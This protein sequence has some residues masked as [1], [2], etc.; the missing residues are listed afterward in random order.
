M[1]AIENNRPRLSELI[2]VTLRD[3]IESG[4]LPA[5]LILEAAPLARFFDLSRTP[6]K[7]ALHGLL[8][9]GLV[10]PTQG[11]GVAVGPTGTPFRQDLAA[12]GLRLPART[13]RSFTQRHWRTRFYPQT[14][15]EI[16]ACL[17]F[18]RFA[19]NV[20]QFAAHKGVS[21]TLANETLV[22]LERLGLIRQQGTRWYA[23]PLTETDIDEHYEMRWLLEPCAL[24]QS[25]A[26]LPAAVLDAA[27]DRAIAAL[28]DP[29][30][31]T[32]AMLDRSETDIHRT[33]VL[34]AP[35]RQMAEAIRRS[36]LPLMATNF[37]LKHTK[38]HGVMHQTLKE[39]FAVLEHLS[40]GDAEGAA[41]ALEAHLK[42]ARQV[43]QTTLRVPNLNFEPPAYM[44]RES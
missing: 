20:S 37:S 11:R 40:H 27:L 5:G 1:T 29:E 34:H 31:I 36:Q 38:A 32:L 16:A 6:V 10:R 14:E 28:A 30:A 13:Q 15:Q 35:N 19:I 41:R 3:Q 18:G 17:P 39:H 12:A 21:R 4:T 7:E 9:A 42:A 43:I 44:I 33:I 25:A 24:V 23:G 22:R 8:E 26:T 2:F